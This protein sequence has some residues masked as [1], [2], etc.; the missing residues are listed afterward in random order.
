MSEESNVTA[1]E[2]DASADAQT[3]SNESARTQP[4]D[5]AADAPSPES[6]PPGRWPRALTSWFRRRPRI[7]SFCAGILAAAVVAVVV[8]VA[9]RPGAQPLKYAGLPAPCA[10]VMAATL[11]KYMPDATSN[12]QSIPS[13]S[14]DQRGICSWSSITGR[15]DRIL[16][17]LVEIYGSSSGLT[18]AQQAYD[19][20]ISVKCPCRGFKI[21]RHAVTG[22]GDQATAVFTTFVGPAG[23]TSAGEIPG[24]TVHVRSGNADITVDYG[25]DPIGSAPPP[26]TIAALL[27]GT[28]AMA[29]DVLAALANPTAAPATAAPSSA[30]PS[31]QGPRYLSPND[32]CTLVKAS[33]LAKYA[34]GATVNRL[35]NPAA[36]PLPT[37]LPGQPQMSTCG[38]GTPNASLFMSLDIY[39]DAVGAQQGFEFDVQASSQ[40]G[41]G[42][43]FNGAQPVRSLGQQATAIFQTEIGNSPSVHLL[44]W[45]GNA[46]FEFDYTD[47]PFS[48]PPGRAAKLAGEIA[49]ARDVLAALPT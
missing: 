27:A 44:V 28:I 21:T 15:E 9:V 20:E 45:S 34:P 32:P 18:D 41:N 16:V 30:S 47:L 31:P 26:P 29:R 33:T 42:A 11:A 37:N 10:V 35:P 49:M 14:I 25:F 43:T 1:P 4:A 36:S 22:L 12:P 13:S 23:K 7:T 17:A 8:L 46:E 5:R 2:P 19:G 3:N 38:W 24:I 40:N 39:P 6:A 48:S